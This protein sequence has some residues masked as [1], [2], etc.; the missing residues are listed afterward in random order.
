[1]KGS[2][3]Y[4]CMLGA[5]LAFV[6]CDNPGPTEEG[7]PP[8][9]IGAPRFARPGTYNPVPLVVTIA[10][11]CQD[12]TGASTPCNIHSDGLGDYINGSQGVGAQIDQYGNYIFDS[13]TTRT[14]FYDF[15]SPLPGYPAN[16]VTTYQYNNHHF[17][18][19]KPRTA[20]DTA[21][22]KPMQNMTV[23][24]VECVALATGVSTSGSVGSRTTYHVLFHYNSEDNINTPTSYAIVTHTDDNTWTMVPVAGCSD[25]HVN[26]GALRSSDES[27]L[28]GYYK[29]PFS[30]KL[31]RQ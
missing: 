6:A 20:A 12:A 9:P 2:A 31:T 25:A 8:A 17:A 26:V 3:R 7:P 15:S 28:Y 11:Q 10:D 24:A 29:L 22:W 23:G 5:A 21:Q 14:V 27:I 30:L 16:P 19:M 18:S 4:A 13:G 1:M